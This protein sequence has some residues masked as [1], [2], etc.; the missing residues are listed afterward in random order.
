MR[1]VVSRLAGAVPHLPQLPPLPGLSLHR[2]RLS[3]RCW[4]GHGRAHVEVRGL[5]HPEADR[6][7]RDLEG[8]LNRLS[9]VH[10]ATVNAV[11]GRVVVDY[12]DGEVSVDDVTATVEAV[13]RLHHRN[14]DRFPERPDHPGDLEPRQR[15]LLA[16]GSDLAGLG[17]GAVGRL[18]RVR[19]LPAELAALVPLV[20]STPWVRRE[21][22]V[23]LGKA[24]TDVGLALANAVAQGLAQGPSGL[25]VDAL[26]RVALLREL[27]ARRRTWLEREPQL[28]GRPG[29][30]QAPPI[31]LPPRGTP[32]P[33]GPVEHEADRSALA[34]LVG[35]GSALVATGDLRRAAS[36]LAAATPKAA[37]LTREAF[38]AELASVIAARG[39]VQFEGE[40]LRRLDRINT[41]VLDARVLLTGRFVLGPLAVLAE[42]DE[43]GDGNGSHRDGPGHDGGAPGRATAEARLRQRAERLFRPEAPQAVRRRADWALGPLRDLG[44]PTPPAARAAARRLGRRGSVVLGLAHKGVL[45]AVFAAEPEIAPLTPA[46]VAAARSVGEVVVAGVGTGVAAGLTVDRVVPGGTGLAAAIRA[47]QS[48]GRAVTLVANGPGTAL[49]AADC[50]IGILE[51]DR[52]PPW[53]AHLLCGPGLDDVCLLLDATATAAQV[54]RRGALLSLYGSIAGGLLAL[55]GPRTGGTERAL[56]SVNVA[57]GAGLASGVWSARALA[58]RP[59]PVPVDRNHWHALETATALSRLGSSPDGLSDA[60]AARRL[61][62]QPLTMERREPGLVQASLDELA[63]PLMPALAAGA[64]VAAASGSVTDAALI[65]VVT[66]LN[67]LIGGVQRV[68][69]D[70]A[71]RELADAS[72]VHVR[73]RRGR[74]ELDVSA[75]SVV[76]GDV[77]LL[78]A[79][80]AVPADCRLL[81]ANGLETDESSL[82][83]ESQLVVKNAQPSAAAH[84]ADRRSMVYEG[85]VVAA[86]QASALVVAAGPLTE[87]GRSATAAE[88]HRGVGGVQVRLAKLVRVTIPVAV[89]SGAALVGAGLL[90]RQ[91]L[92][93]TLSTAVSLAVAAVPEGLPVVATVAQLAAAKRL[94]RRNAL[95]R[96]PPTIETLGRVDTL[97]LDKTGTLTEGRIRLRQVSDGVVCEPLDNL[98]EMGRTILAAGLRASVEHANGVAPPHP[99]DRAVVAAAA[100]VGV[101]PGTGV[102]SWRLV[103]DVPFESGRGYHAALGRTAAGPVLVVKGA[104]EVV[105]PRC[106][107]W[108]RGSGLQPMGEGAVEKIETEVDRLAEQGFRI[109]AVASRAASNRQ[110]LTEDRVER[111]EFLGLLALADQVRPTAADAVATLRAAGVDVVMLTG[112]HPT[113]ATSI[114]AEL[115]IVNGKR[116]VTGGQLDALN[117]KQLG[118]LLPRVSVFARVTPAHKV[119]VVEAY[120][121]RGHTVAMAGDGTNDAP[122]IR[123]ADVGVALGRNGTNAAREAAD[124]VVTDDRIETITDAVVEGRAMWASVRDSV[125]LLLGGNLGEIAFTLGAGLLRSGGSPL[126]ARQL[127]LVNL[128]TDVLP[129]LALAVRP[130]GSTT[131]EALLNEGPDASLGAA[132]TRDVLTR[133]GITAASATGAWLVGRATGTPAHASTVALV[134]LVGAQLGQTL[135][136]GW[137]SPLVVGAGVAS[138]LALGVVV[139]TP[140]LSHFFG[141]RPLGPLGWGIAAGAA[142]AGTAASVVAPVVA[143]TLHRW[144]VRTHP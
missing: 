13:E 44:V 112:D 62:T 15:Q 31:S 57:A 20:E 117:D 96:N 88:G 108:R 64:G 69:T 122:A 118:A 137:R 6:L 124:L 58:R 102:R 144:F 136:T 35:G 133:A 129:A 119:R 38:A 86:G 74:R 101:V 114:G 47:L 39:V 19:R 131:P 65:S 106:V 25:V 22:E 63:N 89:G 143:G 5:D 82:T 7:V 72:A 91:P 2:Q 111:L 130:P 78:R 33:S 140:G 48:E 104:P 56:L 68:G 16:L 92:H 67:A 128:F 85:T 54:S 105:L 49:A 138:G 40:V 127:L 135:V 61:A 41:V 14:R 9:G 18:L 73:V 51:H 94:S 46:I 123:L 107:S 29:H 134:A 42:P 77:V 103:D 43:P 90:R 60:E 26:H 27:D 17:V 132:L 97:L 115:G 66:L 12:A 142:G 23:R 120:Q 80:D 93:R 79:G 24:T 28:C 75:E 30:P 126:N 110:D 8:A 71:I 59:R 125:A 76:P 3:R 87:A 141:C 53:G 109:L 1:S 98:T 32:L 34:A 70:R 113:T 4:V 100:E 139:Q 37:R 95:V 10:W 21:I 83:G 99:T 50:G 81:T 116:V 55:M 84:V 52:P 36:V 45:R 11:L 121:A